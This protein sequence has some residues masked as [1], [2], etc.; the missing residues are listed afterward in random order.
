MKSLIV[1]ALASVAGFACS[2]NGPIN[3]GEAKPI[4]VLVREVE[5]QP[6]G[7]VLI[8]RRDQ[9]Q[10]SALGVWEPGKFQGKVVLPIQKGE[11]WDTTWLADSNSAIV[12]VEGP[13]S[14]AKTK[15]KT[16][17]IYMVDGDTQKAI[18]MFNQTFDEKLAPEVEVN[19]SPSLKH[20]IVT[21]HNSA[22]SSHKVLN[23]GGGSLSD[24]PDLDRAE[25]EGLTGPTWSIDGTAIYSNATRSKF[26]SSEKTGRIIKTVRISSADVTGSTV[27]VTTDET[28]GATSTREI[29]LIRGDSVDVFSTL[30]SNLVFR[31][32]F[33]PPV[34]ATGANVLELMTSNPILRPVRFRG[35]WEGAK[36][37]SAKV[38]P[39]GQ[40][41]LLHFDQSNAQDTS[42]WLTRG[43]EKGAPA[44]LVAVHVTDTWL[45]NTKTGVAYTIDGALF[46]RP[47]NP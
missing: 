33:S 31:I 26:E 8:Y 13:A 20:A 22:G 14:E 46:F 2:Q 19:S 40:S 38:V 25:K 15:S 45:P 6:Q 32:K 27:N 41:I 4:D 36:E 47:I 7:K 34:P 30:T 37:I 10:G 11:S 42:V 1:L 17:K 16:I 29:S 3:L 44:T 35:A 28:K 5:W 21:F 23:L 24:S 18:L 9:E 43:T 39:Q 12:V